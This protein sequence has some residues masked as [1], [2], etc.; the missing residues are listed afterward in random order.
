MVLHVEDN[1]RRLRGL[2]SNN[3]AFVLTLCFYHGWLFSFTWGFP[4][5]SLQVPIGVSEIPLSLCSLVVGVAVMVVLCLIPRM[6]TCSKP[7]LFYIACF[8]MAAGIAAVACSMTI[9][10]EAPLLWYL[11]IAGTGV[12][13]G[14]ATVCWGTTITRFDPSV[15]AVFVACSYL[16]SGFAVAFVSVLPAVASCAVLIALAVLTAV[17]HGHQFAS[18]AK[19]PIKQPVCC[20]DSSP[21]CEGAQPLDVRSSDESFQAD[22]GIRFIGFACLVA[23]LGFSGGL[24]NALSQSFP[25]EVPESYLFAL[26]IA[27]AA[28]MLLASKMP[29]S[30]ESFPLF[31][32]AL[33]L[34]ALA[35]MV[36]GTITGGTLTA[37]AIHSSGFMYFCGLLW[38]FCSMYAQRSRIAARTF[39]GGFVANRLGQIAGTAVGAAIAMPVAQSAGLSTAANVMAYVVLC[40]AI[41]LL[42]R[43]SRP[44]ASR[45]D[46]GRERIGMAQAVEELAWERGL[47]PR[48]TEVLAFLVRG[49]DR[50]YIGSVLHVGPETV[51]THIRH[52]YDKFGIH[53][54][55]ELLACVSERADGLR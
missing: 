7:V 3:A 47:T 6:S 25:M 2:V 27:V 55:A 13:V 1:I 33:G 19:P 9:A 39:V 52:V 16:F 31:Y 24:I 42:A 50:T 15:V 29:G 11:A 30:D 41:V 37:F 4:F 32:R 53:S 40:A 45:E 8:A 17:A 34:I 46:G 21:S 26:A 23:L 14:A 51:K 10:P 35:Y 20:V 28:V 22:A 38:V 5:R 44:R 49:Y 36:L 18:P 12:G 54:I 48:E 43:L